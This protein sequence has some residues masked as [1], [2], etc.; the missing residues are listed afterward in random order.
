M[1]NNHRIKSILTVPA[2]D[3]ASAWMLTK[4]ITYNTRVL[5]SSA[6][7]DLNTSAVSICKP[8]AVVFSPPSWIHCLCNVHWALSRWDETSDQK[9]M[10]CPSGGSGVCEGRVR[11]LP[12]CPHLMGSTGHNC[13]VEGSL[14]NHYVQVS[15]FPKLARGGGEG[16]HS[17]EE[18]HKW[19]CHLYKDTFL[20]HDSPLICFP[21]LCLQ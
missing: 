8:G 12:W 4:Y 10:R 2:T 9:W 5:R 20:L 15:T 21:T 3:S 7:P 11:N 6:S 16:Y 18:C 19:C 17:S 14:V 1:V 13:Q